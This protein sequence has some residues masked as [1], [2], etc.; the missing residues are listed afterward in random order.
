M[1]NRVDRLSLFSIGSNYLYFKKMARLAEVP[2]HK[3]SHERAATEYRARLYQ[4]SHEVEQAIGVTNWQ[5]AHRAGSIAPGK[6]EDET[7]HEYARYL[8]AE[9]E[10]DRLEYLQDD[11]EAY[12]AGRKPDQADP[13]EVARS[14]L[15]KLA[16]RAKLLAAS[17]GHIP[18]TPR[19][20]YDSEVI[21]E[22]IT[23]D[24]AMEPRHATYTLNLSEGL[25]EGWAN[26]ELVY[27]AIRYREAR[28]EGKNKQV[29]VAVADKALRVGS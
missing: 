21:Q 1:S 18:G 8:G 9:R 27:W 4:L 15:V 13:V 5:L 25:A 19:K 26:D 3:Q 24:I 10:L 22:L 28:I 23:R 2:Q 20:S 6:W 16:T 29:S 7:D 12:L 11:V 14:E 17:R